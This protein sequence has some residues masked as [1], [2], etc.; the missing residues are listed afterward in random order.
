M[1][2]PVLI[3]DLDDTLI[4]SF[5]EYVRLHQRIAAD[6]G[7]RV[8]SAAELVHYGPTW[9]DTLARL[10]PG[11]GLDPF[12]AC[13]EE[14]AD[15]HCY[16]A[17]TGVPQAL[18]RLR[19][20]GHSLWIVTKRSRRRLAQ[21]MNQAG[22]GQ[23][24]FEGIFAIEDQPASKPDPRCFAPVWQALGS[25]MAERA[26]YVGDREDDHLAARA[27]GLRFVGVRTGP[28]H[29]TGVDAR[30]SFLDALPDEHVLDTAAELPAWLEG[31]W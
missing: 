24:L 25:T 2:Y 17:I 6:L 18:T 26:L 3:F 29:H 23:D 16:P 31:P 1:R 30:S 5:P 19:A 11:L 8:P 12:M 4:E 27:A 13:Y 9:E 21:R 10:W 15:E 28:E 22:L 7:W 14:L 20:Q